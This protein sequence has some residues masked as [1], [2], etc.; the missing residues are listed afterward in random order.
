MS[1]SPGR[2]SR[3]AAALVQG[4]AR[5]D[6]A[7]QIAGVVLNRVG[8]ERHYQ[9]VKTAI[10]EQAGV[11]VWGYLPWDEALVLGHEGDG[12]SEAAMRSCDHRARIPIASRVDSINVATAAV[13]REIEKQSNMQLFQLVNGYMQQV[14][15]LT[16][17][18]AN[19]Q[20]PQP[21]KE[22]AVAGVKN[23]DIL[24][25]RVFQSFG[26][27]DL[28]SVLMG[29][30]I[31]PMAAPQ[32]MPQAPMMGGGPIDGSDIRAACRRL[33]PFLAAGFRSPVTTKEEDS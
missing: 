25:K 14:L 6:P 16:P 17:I 24:M 10:E 26:S 8:G 3:S 4:Y 29:E 13:N 2:M 31:A 12:L 9:L 21:I 15:G 32:P 11:P 18:L 20:I 1:S 5:F 27:Y 23:M 22:A 28:D 7:V 19:Q 30:I 33:I